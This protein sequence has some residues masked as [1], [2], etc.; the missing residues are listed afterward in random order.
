MDTDVT[1]T[2]REPKRLFVI[3]EVIVGRW[4]ASQSAGKLEL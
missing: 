4:N 1:L 3:T 2:V